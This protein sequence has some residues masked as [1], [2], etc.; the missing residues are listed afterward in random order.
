MT[1][2]NQEALEIYDQLFAGEPPSLELALD[3]WRVRSA[4]PGQRREAIEQLQAL[5]RQYPGNAGLRQTL[6][7]LLFAEKRDPEALALLELLSRDPAHAILLRS[8]NST[9]S[10]GSPWA[11]PAWRP[12]KLSSNAIRHHRCCPRPTRPLPSNV[13]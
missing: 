12:G 3:Y 7:G 2:R 11:L 1:G 9:I 5:D 10:L 4:L 6:V 8:V 13:N